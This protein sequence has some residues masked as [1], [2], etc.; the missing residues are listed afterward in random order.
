MDPEDY[1]VDS[2]FAD[3]PRPNRL[4]FFTTSSLD[5][6]AEHDAVVELLRELE[7]AREPWV[8]ADGYEWMIVASTVDPERR[9][10]AWVE[11]RTR[12]RGHHTDD[13]YLLKARDDAGAL[14]VWE[15]QT[16]NPHFGCT[17]RLL[18][19]VGDAVVSVYQDKHDTWLASL[20]RSG[21]ITRVE[22]SPGWTLQG[23]VL[24]CSAPSGGSA[25]R[26]RLPSLDRV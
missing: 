18:K 21:E 11:W 22:I 20:G 23:D 26:L 13:A 7:S 2:L 5:L 12:E 14:R 1:D 15:I 17:V 8:D 10:V 24:V 16:Y 6:G 3:M 19:W 25:V 9:R 4:G